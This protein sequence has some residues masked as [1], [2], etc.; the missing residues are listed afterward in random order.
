MSNFAFSIRWGDLGCPTTPGNY[1]YQGKMI[2]VK[3]LH[4]DTADGD[5]DA[6]FSVL[7]GTFG[8]KTRYFLVRGSSV[9]DFEGKRIGVIQNL[10][11]HQVSG[12]V[13]YA[14]LA[15]GGLLGFRVQHYS[16]PWEKLTFDER[17]QGYLLD[18]LEARH[19]ALGDR[20]MVSAG[21]ML[22]GRW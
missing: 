2:A 9:F 21:R 10:I 19:I 12:R 15:F 13:L 6:V 17:L 20:L 22:H 3:Q 5:P 18:R 8:G 1:E 14:D 4:I 16:I 7:S 11:V